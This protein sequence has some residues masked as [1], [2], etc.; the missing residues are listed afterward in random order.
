MKRLMIVLALAC[1][2]SM[3]LGCVITPSMGVMSAV[4]VTKSAGEIGDTDVGMSKT[5][6]SQ[7]E[8][9][10]LVAFG[11]GSIKAACDAGGITRIHHV[12]TEVLNVIGIYGRKTI[13]VYGE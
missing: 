12:D 7:T 11:D 10:I 9:I 1:V 2:L 4:M 3:A 8:G 5:G 13:T 6:K